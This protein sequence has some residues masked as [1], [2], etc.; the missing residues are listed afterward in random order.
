MKTSLRIAMIAWIAFIASTAVFAQDWTKAQ[1][2]VLQVVE[3]NWLKTKTGD[4]DGMAANIHEKYQGWNNEAPLP[5]NKERVLKVYKKLNEISKLEDYSI[6]PARI[7]V[8]DNA[9]VVDYYF[10]CQVSNMVGEKKA[11]EE[12][13]GK[14]VEFYV[15]EGG[16]WLLLGDL[17]L[18]NEN[19]KKDSK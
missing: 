2:E 19:E 11:M 7:V 16:K 18:F 3:D 6:N 8:T 14:N 1:K 17:T 9:A 15:K 10:W 4:I 12:S 13:H 5:M